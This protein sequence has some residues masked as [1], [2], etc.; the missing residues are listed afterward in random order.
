MELKELFEKR[1]STR[2]YKNL[3]IESEKIEKV[4]EAARL[5]PSACNAQA[6]KFIVINDPALKNKV[7]Q[8]AASMGMNKFTFEAPV[9]IVCVLEKANATSSVG[10]QI[11][12]K[13][14][15][16]IDMGIAAEHICLQATELGLGSCIIGW[17]NEGKIKKLLHIPRRKRI[18]LII[19]IG[20]PDDKIR[21]KSRK[22]LNEIA[23]YNTYK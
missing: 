7:A 16:W 9:I 4:I 6:W 18:P 12:N 1:Q 5:S 15:K 3:E 17:F 14:Y 22:S 19:T 11:K 21:Q 8:S 23:S 20:Y 10:S 13:N 2:K